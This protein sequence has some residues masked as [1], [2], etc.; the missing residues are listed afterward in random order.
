MLL[1]PAA[2]F[3][4]IIFINYYFRD[5]S[6]IA[7]RE[8]LLIF[9]VV[10]VLSTAING[11]KAEIIWNDGLVHDI[12]YTDFSEPVH[13]YDGPLGQPTTVNVVTIIPSSGEPIPLGPFFNEGLWTYD[14]SQLNISGGEINSLLIY[15]NSQ[16]EISSAFIEGDDFHGPMLMPLMIEGL[17]A[18]EQ[19]QVSMSS[20]TLAEG[21]VA[22]NYSDITISGGDVFGDIE[23]YGESEITISGGQLDIGTSIIGGGGEL[24]FEPY[25]IFA[26]D[27][28]Q[29]TIHGTD[30]KIDDITVGYGLIDVPSGVLTGSLANGG[31]IHKDFFIYD[32]AS[33]M[34]V[35]EPA[36]V[37][38]FGICGL[39]LRRRKV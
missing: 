6:M 33:I 24:I 3:G 7:K 30:F 25:D 13:V 37:L 23:V 2:N 17:V 34:L 15:G 10:A 39:L 19:S 18:N 32:N 21:F 4:T 14:N 1:C 11:A 35:P 22:N 20:G 12:D 36:T 8:F 28:S 9:L 26:S 16:I 31:E 29:F 38:L 27:N 5:K